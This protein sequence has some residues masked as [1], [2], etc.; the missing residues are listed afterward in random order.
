MHNRSE[1]RYTNLIAG[2]DRRPPG[3]DRPG[4]R[5]R[6]RL[7]R[8]PRRPR[9]R[10][11]Q[12]APTTTSRCCATSRRSACWAGRSSSARRGSR[13]S[14]RCSTCRG[15]AARGD[16]R[17]DRAGVAA[18]VDIVRVH[19]VR[20][21]VRAA[22]MADAVVRG[23]P[24]GSRP[25]R[26]ETEARMTDRIVLHDIAFDGAHGVDDEERVSPAA[27][28]G[29]RRA[30]AGP[31]PAGLRRRPGADRRLRPVD[32]TVRQIVESTRFK[33]LETIAETIAHEVLAAFPVDEVVVRVRKPA[34]RLAARSALG[35]G[36]PAAR[37]RADRRLQR[38]PERDA[39]RLEV[40]AGPS[41][42]L[43][44]F[45]SPSRSTVSGTV[46]PGENCE[47]TASS[48]WSVSTVTSLIFVMMSPSWTR[49][50][51][52]DR[53]P[54]PRDRCCSTVRPTRPA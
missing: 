50:S 44:V 30:R 49:P 47:R 25:A 18:G 40:R 45:V 20:E 1:P 38:G 41:V 15:P 32:E 21:N 4:P 10:V 31:A 11:R 33:L 34:G 43:I 14:A 19:D 42:T 6:R 29:R 53:R 2:G 51:P 28:R 54:R 36:D 27:V 9:V 48:G 24:S 37:R 13:P 35:R 23:A 46:S 52:P 12:D 17:D 26:N 7:G 22:R 5:R 16:P 8:D 39:P 3:R